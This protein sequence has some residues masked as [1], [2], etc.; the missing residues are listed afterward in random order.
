VAAKSPILAA[1]ALLGACVPAE[2]GSRYAEAGRCGGPPSGWLQPSDGI[3][4]HRLLLSVR[5]DRAGS[6]HWHGAIISRETLDRYL[7]VAGEMNPRAQ[8]ALVVDEGADCRTVAAIR[9]QLA[10]AAICAEDRLCGEGRF[11]DR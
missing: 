3:A 1:M 9:R 2:T 7:E 6:L 8:I 5:V 4:H 11:R 10:E